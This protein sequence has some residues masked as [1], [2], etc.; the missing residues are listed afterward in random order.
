MY[1]PRIG[2]VRF[3]PILYVLSNGLPSLKH[4]Y[5]TYRPSPNILKWI[6]PQ[7]GKLD[8]SNFY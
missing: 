3:S 2:A 4:L 1:W 5:Q 6:P 8:L 7:E